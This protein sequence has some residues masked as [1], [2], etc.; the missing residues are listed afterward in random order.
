MLAVF[1]ILVSRLPDLS[2]VVNVERKAIFLLCQRV[3]IVVKPKNII[4]L[5]ASQ[6]SPHRPCSPR[7]FS[8]L[9][10]SSPFPPS[11]PLSPH[12]LR[13][14]RI[15]S[16]LPAS[17]PLSRIF[18]VL[19]S[20]PPLS[21]IPQPPFISPPR[22]LALFLHAHPHL[23]STPP[24][25]PISPP[26][27][28]FPHFRLTRV[29]LPPPYLSFPPPPPSRLLSLPIRPSSPSPPIPPQP[30]HPSSPSL[31]FSLSTT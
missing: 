26:P 22:S 24:S 2:A 7:I 17:S 20:C 31:P 3:N 1:L 10:A 30:H 15:F 27:P 13:S 8:V 28:L 18:P 11:S 23:P 5:S 21:F 29:P 16:V 6:L 4:R 14:P 19:P 12:L 25:F 9:L